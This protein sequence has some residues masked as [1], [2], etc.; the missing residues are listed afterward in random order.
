MHGG[1]VINQVLEI[2]PEGLFR[3]V[4]HKRII[5]KKEFIWNFALWRIIRQGETR[6]SK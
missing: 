4:N 5:K 6:N 3:F 1:G 2:V